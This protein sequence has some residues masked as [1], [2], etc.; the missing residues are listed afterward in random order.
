MPTGKI[1]GSIPVTTPLSLS[2]MNPSFLFLPHS[3]R[4]NLTWF[5]LCAVLLGL[6]LVTGARAQTAPAVL[7]P[8]AEALSALVARVRDKLQTGTR[9]AAGLTPELAGGF[10]Q[11]ILL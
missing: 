2:A 10:E 4:R 6:S 5:W 8:P 7:T 11:D 3:P 9:T 1:G